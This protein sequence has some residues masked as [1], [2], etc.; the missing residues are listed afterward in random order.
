V[1]RRPENLCEHEPCRGCPQHRARGAGCAIV[2]A[3]SG[4]PLDEFLRREPCYL[5][6][7]LRRFGQ[8]FLD[9]RPRSLLDADDLVQEVA[10]KLLADP[11][12]RRGGFGQGLGAF[13]AYLRRT[14]T[15]CTVSAGRR[16]LGRMRCGNCRHYAVFSGKC[17]R[18]NHEWT[19]REVTAT[20]DPRALAPPCRGFEVRR[21]PA[22]LT[23]EGE[24]ILAATPPKEDDPEVASEVLAG[25]VALAE[26]HPRAALVV[27][28]RL[29]EGKSYDQLSHIGASTRTLKR[30]YAFGLA[31]LRKRLASF[32]EGLMAPEPGESRYEEGEPRHP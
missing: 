29:L 32:G 26:E 18:A 3:A 14:A 16:E 20:Q 30:D 11:N 6:D 10:T 13:L 25:L 22:E 28:A 5:K 1:D 2:E 24:A 12:V 4:V 7:W 8:R 31:Y 21:M 23:K 27:R 17:L 15:S 9:Y 19:H